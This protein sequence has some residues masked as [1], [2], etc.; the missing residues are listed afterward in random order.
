MSHIQ[1]R[2]KIRATKTSEDSSRNTSTQ[3]LPKIRGPPSDQKYANSVEL[4]TDRAT[5][6]F[7]RRTLCS[8]HG[9]KVRSASVSIDEILP[10]LTSSNDVDLQ[11]YAFIAIIIREYVQTWYHKI[12][13][14]QVFVEELLKIIAH[15]SRALE[16]RVRQVDLESLL[17]DEIPEVLETHIRAF[18]TSHTALHSIPLEHDPRLIYHSI[19][20]LPFLSP[21]PRDHEAISLQ[22]QEKNE[23]A[24]RQLLV[25]GILALL[26]PTED[27]ENSCLTSL[28]VDILS[29]S[30]LG[31]IIEKVSEPW[32]IWEG[33]FNL[34][35]AIKP[36][37]PNS[38]SQVQMEQPI[39]SI[40]H[41][42]T[43][44]WSDKRGVF[45]QFKMSLQRTLWLLLQFLYLLFTT[46]HYTI[47]TYATLS[48]LPYRNG[49]SIRTEG[50]L[51]E[52]DGKSISSRHG[53]LKKPILTMKFWSCGARLL[54]LDMRM[55]WLKASFSMFQWFALTGPGKVGDTDQIIDK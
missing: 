44:D 18:Q 48:T 14:D 20:P 13:S 50:V 5:L 9:D 46:I 42:K 47:S 41:S 24:Y 54:D 30:V 23:S 8:Q 34:T 17:L 43:H 28:V 36:Q 10:C 2:P 45:C 29:E 11:L 12:T 25:E 21:I 40:S 15:C 35:Q 52:N 1:S 19:W 31:G 37:I 51:H 32:L 6:F 26:L 22:Q 27:L 16:Q 7:I 3:S 4:L 53:S 49:A 33:I 39:S 55:P 38:C